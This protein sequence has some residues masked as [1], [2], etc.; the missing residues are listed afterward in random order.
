LPVELRAKGRPLT[1]AALA[2][3][4]DSFPQLIGGF[5]H[6]PPDSGPDP[7]G[8]FRL[9]VRAFL[10]IERMIRIYAAPD[11]VFPQVGKGIIKNNVETAYQ[12]INALFHR[13]TAYLQTH[14]NIGKPQSGRITDMEKYF[15]ILSGRYILGRLS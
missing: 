6:R 8:C 11:G 4:F 5:F 1:T 12:E 2:A 7:N 10:F 14:Q 15:V 3:V 13:V 9:V